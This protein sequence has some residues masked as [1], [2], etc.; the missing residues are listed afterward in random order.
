MNRGLAAA[1]LLCQNKGEGPGA[2]AGRGAG[3][4]SF[5]P[6]AASTAPPGPERCSS[7]PSPGAIIAASGLSAPCHPIF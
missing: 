2:S 6:P 1:L 4:A 5:A 3:P 7:A